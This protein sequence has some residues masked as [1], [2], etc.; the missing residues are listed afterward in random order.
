MK[1]KV[2]DTSDDFKK[3]LLFESTSGLQVSS[4]ILAVGFLSI[5][6]IPKYI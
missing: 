3:D 5:Q 4:A 6:S 2:E 1:R